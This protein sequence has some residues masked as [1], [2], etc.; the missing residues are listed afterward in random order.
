[1][2]QDSGSTVVRTFSRLARARTRNH[3]PADESDVSQ[4][5][6]EGEISLAACTNVP[7]LVTGDTLATARRVACAIQQRLEPRR[8]PV[9]VIDCAVAG[10]SLVELLDARTGSIVLED[11]G[12]LGDQAQ[13][14]LFGF[15]ENRLG[16]ASSDSR[17]VH[18][19]STALTDFYA[20][21]KAGKFREALFY[22][23]NIIH[24][25][26]SRRTTVELS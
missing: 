3:T 19:I 4:S 14:L 6:L 26:V 2:A 8:M 12:S 9:A 16:N 13:A 10:D 20:C 15:L 18:I 22:R 11:V 25:S 17:H 1:M 7:V 21:V 23:L 24:I 5:A